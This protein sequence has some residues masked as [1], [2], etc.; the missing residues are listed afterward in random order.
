MS[1]QR[2]VFFDNEVL[3]ETRFAS[4]KVLDVPTD[5][6]AL[7]FNPSALKSVL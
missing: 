1:S 6:K 2:V 5:F 7:R 3:K 4:N